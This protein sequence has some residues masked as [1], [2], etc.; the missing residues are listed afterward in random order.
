MRLW[1]SPPHA[2]AYLPGR[3][4]T[5]RALMTRDMP[6]ETYRAFMDANFR[7]SGSIIYQP[8]CAGCRACQSL[9]VLTGEFQMNK[10]QRRCWRRN[11]DIIV[12]VND[13]VPNAE[14]FAIYQ[15]YLQTWHER[16]D[17]SYDEFCDFLYESPVPSLEFEYRD[18]SKKLLAIGI[19]DHSSQSLS[20]VYFYFDPS[21]CNRSPGTFGALWEIRWAAEHG[22]PFYYL[23]YWVDGCAAMEYKASF[24]PHQILGADGIWRDHAKNT[25][26]HITP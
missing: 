3:Q 23:G 18:A 24:H 4:A 8:T 10:S 1:E 2:C 6:A 7:R 12:S 17:G 21:E 25:S 19:C 11:D 14:K 13:P 15:R 16:Q 20:S 9:R 26:R 5:M 22:V